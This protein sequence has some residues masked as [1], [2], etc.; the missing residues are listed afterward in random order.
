MSGDRKKI[1]DEG[2][3]APDAR[4]EVRASS[5]LFQPGPNSTLFDDQAQE[6]AVA[7]AVSDQVLGQAETDPLAA[8]AE[9]PA[10][11]I[12]ASVDLGPSGTDATHLNLKASL[13]DTRPSPMVNRHELEAQLQRQGFRADDP[14]EAVDG[15]VAGK[16]GSED[17]VP[18]PRAPARRIV[19]PAETTAPGVLGSAED[20]HPPSTGV[21]RLVEA[22][23]RPVPSSSEPLVI[24]TDLT[25]EIS[26][27]VKAERPKMVATLTFVPESDEE[28]GAPPKRERGV[29]KDES[30][31]ERIGQP[32]RS[33][34]PTPK[35]RSQAPPRRPTPGLWA[36]VTESRTHMAAAAFAA[37]ALALLVAVVVV[38]LQ[39]ARAPA[40]MSRPLEAPKSSD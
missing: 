14:I 16:F 18:P 15:T 23:A 39:Q 29:P 20:S 28:A 22:Y 12:S 25:G 31:L 9:A 5:G 34:P 11:S 3:T 33:V 17:S 4:P 30:L 32:V 26:L 27:E 1:P 24:P 19:E 7:R 10:P 36:F 37:L 6:D 38:Q 8:R 40:I 21:E 35:R 2:T 13:D